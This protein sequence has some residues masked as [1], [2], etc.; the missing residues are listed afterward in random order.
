MALGR[1]K[2]SIKITQEYLEEGWPQR[3]DRMDRL[4]RARHAGFLGDLDVYSREQ[5]DNEPIFRDFFRPR[6]LGWGTATAIPIPTGDMLVFDLERRFDAGPVGAET[7]RRLD[8]LRPHLARAGLLSCRLAFE[9]ARAAVLALE[10][11][12]IPGLLDWA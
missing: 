7:I 8:S 10:H 1:L 6:G 3:T 11:V 4:L 5:I 9:R 12:G 2:R